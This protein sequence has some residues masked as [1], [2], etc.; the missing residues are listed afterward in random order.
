MLFKLIKRRV[1]EFFCLF[2]FFL[3][4]KKKKEIPEY[5]RLAALLSAVFCQRGGVLVPC[6]KANMLQERR[7]TLLI[8]SSPPFF[9]FLFFPPRRSWKSKW[10]PSVSG[11]PPRQYARTR[12]ATNLS[13]LLSAFLHTFCP[14]SFFSR[15]NARPRFLFKCVITPPATAAH[16]SSACGGVA[17]DLL[18]IYGSGRLK[19][20]K[21]FG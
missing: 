21:I 12:T 5:S 17:G 19:V 9:F 16:T 7:D 13:L 6:L 14:L 2:F 3:F 20:L 15:L 18:V 1:A 10:Q 11:P 8:H 4:G